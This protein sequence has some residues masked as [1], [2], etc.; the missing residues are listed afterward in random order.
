MDLITVDISNLK[1]NPEKL[2]LLNEIQTV[3]ILAKSAKTISY[4]ILTNLSK[5]YFREY[6]V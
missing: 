5:R 2:D 3:E 4:E 1:F 6:H